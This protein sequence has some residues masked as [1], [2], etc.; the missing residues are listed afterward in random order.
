MRVGTSGREWHAV[1]GTVARPKKL[2]A[3]RIFE[4]A[5]KTITISILT[6]W[7]LCDVSVLQWSIEKGRIVDLSTTSFAASS[8]FYII[9]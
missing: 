1:G 3:L 7:P 5:N 2:G 9:R 6:K 4:G 8:K